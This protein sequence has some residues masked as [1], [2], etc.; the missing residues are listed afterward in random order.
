MTSIGTNCQNKLKAIRLWL[1]ILNDSA[2]DWL[3]KRSIQKKKS[4]TASN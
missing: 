3:R 4:M 1:G 2:S